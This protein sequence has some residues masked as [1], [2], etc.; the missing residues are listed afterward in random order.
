MN[1]EIFTL[2][3]FAEQSKLGSLSIKNTLDTLNIAKIPV[4]L[5]DCHVALRV[6]FLSEEAGEH[7]V[8]ISIVDPDSKVIHSV[9]GKSPVRI[10]SYEN[11]GTLNLVFRIE[12][13][14]LATFGRHSIILTIDG[15][16][17]CKLPL[18]VRKAT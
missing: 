5:D 10:P 2:C 11:S 6:R 16:D 3:Q 14:P 17:L 7:V 13:I 15:N 8:K 4:V 12:K 9:D 1:I 18:H